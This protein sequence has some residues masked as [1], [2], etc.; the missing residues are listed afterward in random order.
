VAVVGELAAVALLTQS[1]VIGP[2]LTTLFG[3][4]ILKRIAVE[5]RALRA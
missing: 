3:W 5:Q 2:V 4:L 1:F